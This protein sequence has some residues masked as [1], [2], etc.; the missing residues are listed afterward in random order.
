MDETEDGLGPSA[1]QSE[2]QDGAILRTAACID[3]IVLD[4]RASGSPMGF[5]E[6]PYGPARSI[7]PII[8]RYR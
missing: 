8:A 4:K 6:T 3:H 7:I 1:V 2:N 5:V